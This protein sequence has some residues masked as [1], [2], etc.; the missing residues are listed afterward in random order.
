MSK[1][2]LYVFQELKSG[3]PGGFVTHIDHVRGADMLGQMVNITYSELLL[4]TRNNNLIPG[5]QYRITDFVTKCNDAGS[6]DGITTRSAGNAFDIIVI[7]DS[8]DTLNENA[9]ALIHDGDTYFA[10]SNLAA[11]QLKYSIDN[12]TSRFAWAVPE[13]EGGKG[14]IYYMKDEFNN[15]CFYDFKN[16]QYLKDDK[17]HYTFSIITQSMFDLSVFTLYDGSII[18]GTLALQNCCNNKIS[19]YKTPQSPTQRLNNIILSSE[20]MINEWMDSSSFVCINNYIEETCHS[21]YLP[22]AS[23]NHIGQNCYNIDAIDNF[24]FNHIGQN[25]YNIKNVSSIEYSTI[26]DN[27]HVLFENFGWCE[28]ITVGNDCSGIKT[29][30]NYSPSLQRCV[31]GKNCRNITLSGNNSNQYWNDYFFEDNTGVKA[32][33]TLT[34]TNPETTTSVGQYKFYKTKIATNSAGEVKIYCEADLI[35]NIPVIQYIA[36]ESSMPETPTEGVLYL[37]GEEEPTLISFTI[38]NT[39]YQ[40][41]EGMSWGEWVESDYNTYGLKIIDDYIWTESGSNV[42]VKNSTDSSSR[43]TTNEMIESNFTYYQFASGG[44][45]D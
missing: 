3:V 30:D 5:R 35:T 34:I 41:E 8:T 25:C 37:I 6:V 12:D 40:A 33:E 14:V 44:S 17:Y 1:E 43:V 19:V 31:F 42:I 27:C 13:S 22:K 7:A 45:S 26:G 21:L 23:F 15:E 36:N 9:R 39:S 11:W 16:I 20:Q 32:G 4:L 29:I 28:Y 18:L 10:G 38:N 24:S 2:N